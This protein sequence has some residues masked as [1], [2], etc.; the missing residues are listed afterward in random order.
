MH[1]LRVALL[2]NPAA[3]GGASGR[4]LPA[5]HRALTRAG[6]SLDVFE[7]RRPE[8]AGRVVDDCRRRGVD[9][10]AIAGGDG[11]INAV[12]QA[13]VD[14]M[15]EPVSGPP[16][17]I[18][19]TG[20]GDDFARTLAVGGDL[21]AAVD[22]LLACDPRPFDLGVLQLTTTTGAVAHRAFLNI[23]SFGLAAI[24]DRLVG[25]SPAWLPGR[26]A[27]YLA[28][29]RGLA[30]YRNLPV[31]VTVDGEPWLESPIVN[32]MIANGR[33][34]GGG[35]RIAPDADPADGAFDV[36]AIGDL[37]KLRTLALTRAVYAGTHVGRP[38]ITATRGR[39]VEACP[40]APSD[41][42][43]ID[44]D[45]ETPGRLPLTARVEPGAIWIR[46]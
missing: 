6:T 13:Y 44:M 46:A 7:T 41:V 45:G 25:A 30:G 42:V 22:R 35:M 32:V 18:L 16:I 31:R 40:V 12:C 34:F 2:V 1:R 37:G 11:T 21:D 14:A 27:F 29:V 17:A 43:L 38:R 10:L 36:V 15:G 4:R 23:A 5:L 9:V 8:D 39:L 33:F 26:A 3:G 28:T 24:T 20:T 19:P